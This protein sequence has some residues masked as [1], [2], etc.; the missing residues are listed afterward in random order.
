MAYVAYEL[1][2][3]PTASQHLQDTLQFS[4]LYRIPAW[5]IL[6]FPAAAFILLHEGE[7]EKATELLAL[8]FHHP[9]SPTELLS[10]W[11]LIT[12]LRDKMGA[13][14]DPDAFDTAWTRG[15]ALDMTEAVSMLE[16]HFQIEDDSF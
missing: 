8:A 9:A 15:Q 4:S 2:E 1:D 5:L 12:H 11:T 16:D 13:E 14:L 3:F 7:G 6:C 10:R